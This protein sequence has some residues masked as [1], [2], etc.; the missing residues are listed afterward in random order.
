MSELT[1]RQKLFITE[2]LIDRN[3]T[4]AAI[5]A[6]FSENGAAVQ[7]A[8]L[9]SNV[10][11]ASEI[12]KRTEKHAEK[13]GLTA[14][15]VLKEIERL[16]FSD[17]RKLLNED[18]SLKATSEWDDD[19]AAS[20]A[21]VEIFEEFEG[22][23]EARELVGYT[24]KLKIWDKNAALEK[25]AKHLGLYEKDNAQQRPNIVMQMANIGPE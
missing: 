16:C 15:R 4:Q 2:Y 6:G 13:S 17:T 24:K 23:G 12:E 20:V 11:I 22:K 3:G 19:T 1:P 7:A 10:N 25:A 9:L 14:E 8:R 18:G 21:G 5:R